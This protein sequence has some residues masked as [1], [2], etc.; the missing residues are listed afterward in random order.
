MANT[1]SQ[2]SQLAAIIA[3]TRRIE[4]DSTYS[5][6]GHFEASKSWNGWHYWIGVPTAL[7]AALAGVSAVSNEP[8]AAAVLSFAVAVTAALSTFLKPSDRAAQHLAAGN[9]FKAL[10]NDARIFREV[11]CRAPITTEQLSARL[12]E[13]NVRRNELNSQSPQIPRRAFKKARKGIEAGEA[14]YAA[15]A[16]RQK[17]R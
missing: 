1:E 14:S 11:D 6:K 3:E 5:A 8:V 10:Q 13:L 2:P 4:E 9:A 17:R 16:R 15:D 7:A 12:N